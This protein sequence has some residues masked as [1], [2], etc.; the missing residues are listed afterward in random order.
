[1]S[2]DQAVEAARTR[3]QRLVEEIALLAK[4]DLATE[5]FLPEFLNRVVKA[6]DGRGGGVWLVGQRSAEGKSEFQLAAQ[7][8]FESSGFQA[9]ELQRGL[10]LRALT[11]CVNQRSPIVI[12]PM[13][14]QAAPGTA[15]AELA[16]L[17]GEAP[18][19]P[20]NRTPFPFLHVPLPLKDQIL[21][22]VQVW[23]QPY[24]SV[25]NYREFA[26]FLVQLSSYVEG[27]FQSRR[28]GTLVVETQRLQHLLKY[29]AD[30]AGSLD[31][32]EVSREAEFVSG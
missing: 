25:E 15:E 30:L 23:L 1:M 16:Q 3:I 11:E 27:H 24:V 6:C 13:Q 32:L 28:L 10:I 19:Q 7:V 4:K 31:P 5:Q 18:Q 17:R 29:T 14:A 9:D 8:D 20:Q 12:Q 21:G 26:Q 22:V 2:Q